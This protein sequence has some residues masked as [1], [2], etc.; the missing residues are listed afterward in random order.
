MAALETIRVKFGVLITVLIAVALLSFIVDFNTL[1]TIFS[2]CSSKNDVGEIDGKSISVMDFQEELDKVT[3]ATEFVTGSSSQNEQQQAY[4]REMAWQTFIGRYLIEKNAEKAGLNVSS[5]EMKDIIAGN[6]GSPVF[7]NAPVWNGAFSPDF[8]REFI[9]FKDSDETGRAQL[10]WNNLIENTELQQYAMKYTSLF[11]QG[12]FVNPLSVVNQMAENN[13]TFDVEFVMLPYGYAKD[14]TIVVS[15]AEIKD[16][17]NAHKDF[18]TQ[19]ASR[20]IEYVVFEVKPSDDDIALAN[21]AVAEA[22]ET[23]ATTD[24]MKS[25]LLANSER[26]YDEHWYKAGEL[27]SVS[28]EVNDYAFGKN[29]SVSEVLTKGNTF[30]AV[31]LMETAMVPDSVYVKFAPAMDVKVDSLLDAAEPMW[32]TQTPG[33]ESVMTAKKGQKVTVNGVAFKVLDST[34]PVEKRRVA[35]LEKTAVASDQTRNDYYSKANSL[36]SKIDGKYENFEN[37]LSEEGVI[38]HPVNRMLESS[39]NLGAITNTRQVTRWAYDA[40]KGDVSGIMTIDNKYF[41]IAVLK[42]IHK[43]GYAPVADVTPR[44]E[45]I[46]YDGKLAE[47]KT[48]ETA[49]KINGLTDMEAVAAALGT[50]VST[51]EDLSFASMSGYGLDPKFIGAASVAEEGKICGPVAGTIG[52]YVYKVTGR[53]TGAFY[54]ED[55]AKAGDIQKAQY[56]VQMLGKVMEDAG[57]VKDNRARFY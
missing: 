55:D 29:A 4:I 34:K 17:Y 37:A 7:A 9:S 35:I 43:E 47:K 15:E 10:Y 8:V 11:A 20:D 36:S 31:R 32:I 45:R 3:M 54:T 13:N 39:D 42:N 12:D 14:T 22:Y 1:P 6:I 25:F 2:S 19:P 28:K 16:Y 23:F 48:A 40:K 24:N 30:Y 26:Q 51:K 21:N 56:D 46:L 57:E 44:I 50:T 53:D 52:V 27:N 41:V 38:S 33:Y 49:E 18:F 5:E